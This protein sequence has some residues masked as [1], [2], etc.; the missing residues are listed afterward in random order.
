MYIHNYGESYISLLTLLGT[1][2]TLDLSAERSIPGS[3]EVG[4]RSGKLHGQKTDIRYGSGRCGLSPP[5][6]FDRGLVVSPPSPRNILV[7]L[8]FDV[9]DASR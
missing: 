1:F 6:G 7:S 2:R 5:I 3:I 8:M 4:Y 9:L